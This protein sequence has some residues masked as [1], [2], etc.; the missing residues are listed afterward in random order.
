MGLMRR[1][2]SVLPCKRSFG[3]EHA[4]EMRM[5]M[6]AVT[7]H[8]FVTEDKQNRDNPFGN[9]RARK[10][11]VGIRVHVCSSLQMEEEDRCSW[12]GHHQQNQ[13]QIEG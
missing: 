1:S 12:P 6:V 4:K 8:I 7:C 10:A 3:Q 9:L 11:E 5:D 13:K 2:E